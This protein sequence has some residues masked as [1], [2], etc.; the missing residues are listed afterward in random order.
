MGRRHPDYAIPGDW[1][2]RAEC[3]RRGANM[4]VNEKQTARSA[5]SEARKTICRACPVLA[6]CRT[7][8]LTSPDPALGHIAG[9]LHPDERSRARRR[10]AAAR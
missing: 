8:A 7:W 4:G 2:D 10:G 5:A 3:S 1:A 6:E 9:G